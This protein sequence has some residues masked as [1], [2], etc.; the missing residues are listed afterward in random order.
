MQEE[1]NQFERNQVWKLV[2][3]PNDHPIIGTKW[4]FRNKLDEHGIVIRNKARLVPKGYN[5]EK[6]IDYEETY[7]L[8]ARLEAIRMLLVFASIMDFKLYQMDI[9]SAF[10][11]GFIQ[12]EVYV[13]QP[14]GFENSD[15]SNHVFKLKKALYGLKQAPRAWYERLSRF[16]LEKGFTRGKVDTTLFIKRKMHDI[17][18]VQIYIDDIIF[19]ATNDSLC[20]EF[21][22]D[23]QSEF[24]MSMMGELN[25]FLGLQIKQTKNGI[26]ISQ[27][28]Y[29]KELLKRFG[30]EN[31]KQMATPMSTACY[32]DK[33]DA[34]QLV[35]IKKYI[36]MIKSLLYLLASRP[37]IM[38]SVCMCA[39]YQANPKE[40]HLSAIKR[41]M[42]YLLGTINL[43]LWYPNNSS[44]NLVGYSDS[45]F[46]RC[47]TD[48]KST[49]GTCH[50]IGS[51]L[52]SWHSKKQNS[53]A[54]STAEAKYISAGSSCA[55]IL[56]MRQQLSDYGLMLDS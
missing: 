55:Q 4:V 44:Y 33:D 25:F 19:G 16:L 34:G 48:R 6:G 13:D 53:V 32:L 1:L 3:R 41:I 8:V 11:N 38:F 2:D 23:M 20:K 14:P 49:S 46:A 31:A 47:K 42:R 54:L 22:N 51:A 17:L 10:L 43:G 30:M 50:F 45:D 29:S 28:K 21:S 27:A 9:K 35:Y 56:W 40:S 12:E 37:D 24:E 18:L 26:F 36:G 7:A 39:R 5:Q 52:V 15:L